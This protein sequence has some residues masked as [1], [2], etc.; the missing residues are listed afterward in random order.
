MTAGDP[1]FPSNL[2]ISASTRGVVKVAVEGVQDADEAD[3]AAQDV[4]TFGIAGRTWEAAYFLRHYLTPPSA[5]STPPIFDPP[6]PLFTL[7]PPPASPSPSPSS[8]SQ[9]RRRR[10]IVELGSGTGFLSLSLAPYLSADDTLLLTDLDNV[11][12][13]LSSNLA[14]ARTRWR[15]KAASQPFAEP[16]V[17]VTPLPWGDAL[18]LS[19]LLALPSGRPDIVLASDLIYF[20]FLYAP[21]LRTLIGLTDP[22]EGEG[23][24][25]GKGRETTVVFSYKV[26]SLTREQPFWDAFGRWFSFTPVYLGTPV[27]PSPPASPTPPSSSPPSS[28]P[29]AASPV[30]STAPAPQPAPRLSWSRFGARTPSSS[31]SIPG[32]TDELYIFLCTRHASTLSPSFSAEELE[33]VTDEELLQGRGRGRGE[34]SGAGQFEE[35]LMMGLGFDEE[36]EEG[37]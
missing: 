3:D 22:R 19:R 18:A 21:L 31:S 10:T 9:K 27:P 30:S 5:F 17:R 16:D 2:A 20:E 35:L 12:P 4:A 13:L 8:A 26:R 6:C 24:G 15:S 23:E 11:C 36:E 28:L 7:P 1:N 33:G 29:A 34:E 37:W 32:S 25:E 14:A